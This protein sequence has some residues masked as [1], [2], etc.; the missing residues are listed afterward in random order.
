MS[1][2]SMLGFSRNLEENRSP[3]KQGLRQ[4]LDTKLIAVLLVTAYKF[5]GN[6]LNVQSR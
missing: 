3:E 6:K 2:L 4:I 5:S 1:C